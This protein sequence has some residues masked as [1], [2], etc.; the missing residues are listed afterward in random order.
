MSGLIHPTAV[1]ED[2]ASIGENTQIGAFC[3]IGSNVTIGANSVLHSH[4]VI[5][6][7]TTLGE[8]N[9][10]F[11]FAVLGKAPQHNSYEGEASTLVIGDRNVIREHA[12]IH[13]GTKV[14]AMTT[15][16]GN[17]NKFFG[18]TH[19][20]HDC[21]VGNNI[22]MTNGTLVG[23]HAVIEDYVILGGNSGVKQFSRIG[24]H[25][26]VS[27]MTFVTTDIIP[28]GNVFGSKAELVGL[29]LIGMKRRGFS[30]DDISTVRRAYR[31]LFAEEGTFSER[32]EEVQSLYASN[33]YVEQ[34]LKFIK[35]TGDRPLC[36]PARQS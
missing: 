14:G 27:G 34:I 24:A 1:I 6:G 17:D 35:D 36:H 9:E 29:N 21:V 11:S 20:A 10:V 25:A 13:P 2:G 16:I 28:F 7:H 15:I 5:D 22:I 18:S 30:K 4:V 23:G 31:M 19:V 12:T 33:Q 32:L 8:S 26:M 3:H